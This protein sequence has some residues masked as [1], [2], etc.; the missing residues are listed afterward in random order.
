MPTSPLVN[1]TVVA[2]SEDFPTGTAASTLIFA[3]TPV[4]GAIHL[5]ALDRGKN[6]LFYLFFYKLFL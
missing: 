4:G 6:F 1:A 3:T 5:E 2:V